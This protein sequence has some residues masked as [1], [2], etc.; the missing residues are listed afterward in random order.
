MTKQEIE[1]LGDLARETPLFAKY[2]LTILENSA[3]KEEREKSAEYFSAANPN[4]ILSL[5]DRLEKAEEVI[6]YYADIDN[7]TLDSGVDYLS[8]YKTCICFDN[9]EIKTGK[10]KEDFYG[11]KKIETIKTGGKRA[12]A[13]LKENE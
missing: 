2:F 4:A 7:W 12:R 8:D 3:T 1:K 10:Y 5:I 13:W 11:N 9:E 6:E